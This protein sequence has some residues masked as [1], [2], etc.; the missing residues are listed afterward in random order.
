VNKKFLQATIVLMFLSTA[1][2]QVATQSAHSPAITRVSQQSQS[3]IST[4]TPV[5]FLSPTLHE[6]HQE[7][8]STTVSPTPLPDIPTFTPTFDVRT[9]ITATPAPKAECPI[10]DPSLKA[11]FYVPS[12]PD[13][14]ATDMCIFG[15]TDKTILNFLNSGGNPKAAISHLRTADNGN[16]ET[17]AYQDVTN[18]SIPD[19]I[20]IDFGMQKQLHVLYCSTG[21]YKSFSTETVPFDF[22]PAFDKPVIADLNQNHLPEIL[23]Y[24]GAG[25]ACCKISIL[26]WNGTTFEDLSPGVFSQIPVKIEDI[27][28]N[29]TKEM[30]G[31]ANTETYPV[32]LNRFDTTVFSWNGNTYELTKEIFSQPIFRV[33]AVYDGDW[34]TLNKEYDKALSS[35]QT[36]IDDLTLES[37]S[38][39]RSLYEQRKWESHSNL[40]SEPTP[41]PDPV[42][43]PHLAAYAYYRIMLIDMAQ[44]HESDAGTVYKTL[45]QK[46]SGDPYGKPYVELANVFWDNY[47]SNQKMYEGCAAAIQYAVEHPDILAPLGSDYHSLQSHTYGPTDICPFR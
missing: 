11:D 12:V 22:D 37:W 21:Q 41:L 14:L 34:E 40:A 42:E 7:P 30:V 36:A 44:G 13:C 16:Y 17:Y 4:S 1:C 2:S 29:G 32:G 20:F 33:Q 47:H 39:A 35:Y 46:F 43:Y 6:S 19:L 23:F 5:P 18:D 28:K 26:E 45:Q 10:V 27:D 24:H 25:V 15:G 9:I 38:E 8:T 3:I 31:G